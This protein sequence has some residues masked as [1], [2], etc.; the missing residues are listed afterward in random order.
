MTRALHIGRG[1]GWA[2]DGGGATIL[3][4]GP[5]GARGAGSAGA[6]EAVRSG[7]ARATC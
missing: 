7:A 2:G 1:P 3:R 6:Q 5:A 4:A